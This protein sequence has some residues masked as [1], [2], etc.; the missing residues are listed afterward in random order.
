[1]TGM[2]QVKALLDEAR[3]LTLDKVI[4]LGVSEENGSV[5]IHNVGNDIDAV[6]LV[7]AFVS[8]LELSILEDLYARTKPNLN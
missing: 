2:E 4:V 6:F 7:K 5:V 3:A 1:M 8:T